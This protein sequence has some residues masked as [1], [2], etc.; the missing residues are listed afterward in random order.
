MGFSKQEYWNGLSFPPP[1]DLPDP[2]IQLVT[3]GSPAGGFF[4]SKS[5]GKPQDMWG[6]WSFPFT[7]L[8]F[9]KPPPVTQ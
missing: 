4:T 7:F 3:L 9:Q 8:C 2:G 6:T 5:P 1:G